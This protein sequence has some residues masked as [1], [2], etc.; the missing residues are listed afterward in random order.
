MCKFNDKYKK[1]IDILETT[2]EKQEE[3]KKKV[4]WAGAIIIFIVLGISYVTS[5]YSNITN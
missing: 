1:K 3:F 5:I 4:Y 2:V